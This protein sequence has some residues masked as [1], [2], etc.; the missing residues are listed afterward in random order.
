MKRVLLACGLVLVAA[1][2]ALLGTDVLRWRGHLERADVALAA[3][4]RDQGIWRPDTV[5]PAGVGERLLSAGDDVTFRRAVQDFRF[6][7]SVSVDE[8]RRGAGGERRS[9]V[10]VALVRAAVGSAAPEL[11]SQARTFHGVL[12]VEEVRSTE[13]PPEIFLRRALADFQEAARLDPSNEAAKENVELVLRILATVQRV[14]AGRLPAGA[15]PEQG[16]VGRRGNVP[17]GRGF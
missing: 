6:R 5:L 4:A 17:A 7:R 16:Q 8:R 1:T 12:V 3:G 14:R 2:L 15:G 9:S 13:V 10:D 11:R